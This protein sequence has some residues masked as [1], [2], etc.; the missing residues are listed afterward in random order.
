MRINEPQVN[1]TPVSENGILITWPEKI[2]PQQ[3]QDIL[4]VEH[5][6]R[7]ELNS[8]L[9]DCIVS[10]S[11]LMVF[12]HFDR[13]QTASIVQ[14]L[15]KIVN[16]KVDFGDEY[17]FIASGKL[18]EI[19]VCYHA[20]LALDLAAVAHSCNL[21]TEEVIHLH[22]HTN[23]HAYALGF[24]AGFCYLGKVSHKLNLPRMN[25][26]RTQVPKGAVAIA[27]QQTAVYPTSSP[28][29]WHILGQ[30]PLSMYKTATDKNYA[31]PLISVGDT[32]KFHQI[33][34]AEF[35]AITHGEQS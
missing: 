8:E 25:T 26:P 23:Y 33:S 9:I 24:T 15:I 14:K 30:T 32:V 19:P 7:R 29:G 10:Y 34:L 12:Y 16:Q 5:G 35:N 27:E 11:S 2:S 1:V 3:H 28:G 20:S 31:L 22:S 21:T 6:I 18:I 13:I 17:K 4:R